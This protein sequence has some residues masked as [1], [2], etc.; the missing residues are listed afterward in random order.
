MVGF[1][2]PSVIATYVCLFSSCFG[3]Y[4]ALNGNIPAA[5]ICLI[6]SGILDTIDGAI[7]GLVRRNKDERTF[8]IQIDSLCDAFCFGV[9]P[10]CIAY[11][12]GMN[13]GIEMVILF[14][15][16]LAGIIRLAYYN[17]LEQKKL[18]RTLEGHDSEEKLR[19]KDVAR[20][21]KAICWGMPI[22]SISFIF[23]SCVVIGMILSRVIPSLN[24]EDVLR[25]V[26]RLVVC[27][28]IP[29]MVIRFKVGKPGK[30]GKIILGVAAVVLSVALIVLFV[31][32]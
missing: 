7:A 30:I 15:L 4:A 17:V 5:L 27:F 22:T 14:L 31:N 3:A 24:S 6:I 13:S 29:A 20:P 1:Y 32:K 25:W 18:N 8:G 28:C 23:P 21:E 11:K 26:A 2:N 19:A 16:V 9:L 12:L 10:A